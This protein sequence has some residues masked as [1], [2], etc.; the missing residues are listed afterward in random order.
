MEH[1]Y[2]SIGEDWMD[3]HDLYTDAVS[4]YPDRSHFVEVGCWKG[5]SSAYLAVEI[6]KS[7][8][9]IKFDCIDTWQGSE[10]HIDPNS[11]YYS[12]ELANDKDW[13]YY[14]FLKNV[15]PARDFIN[16]IRMASL[17]ASKLYEDRSLDFVFIDAAHDYTNVYRDILSWYPKVKVGGIISGHDYTTYD[18]VK[19][20][21]DDYFKGK[22]ISL[23]NSYWVHVK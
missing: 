20:A 12:K 4:Y 16:P 21:V 7:G 3:F 14:E 2:H 1:F 10:E 15:S 11:F 6:A 17:D 22:K 8:K 19:C 18:G 5:R 9:N 23:K 13:L